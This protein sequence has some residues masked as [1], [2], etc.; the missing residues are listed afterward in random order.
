MNVLLF[1]GERL[2]KEDEL[3]NT[4]DR[5]Q[6]KA[7]GRV[8]EQERDLSKLWLKYQTKIAMFGME[9]QTA[10]DSAMPLRIISY[11]GASYRAQYHSG[12]PSKQSKQQ[13]ADSYYPV[14]TLVLHFGYE[15]RWN[16]AQK[17]SDLIDVPDMVR[18]YFQDYQINVFDIAYLTDEQL[19]MFQSDFKIVADYFVQMQRNGGNYVPSTYEIHHVDEVL[20]LMS[21]LTNDN[22]FEEMENDLIAEGGKITM[23]EVLDRVEQRGIERGIAQGIEQGK[24]SILI[25]L[26]SNGIITIEQAAQKAGVDVDT[27]RKNIES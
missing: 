10:A 12:K 1:H 15:H 25:E 8:H 6:Y 24:K 19:T 5:S 27:F 21:V 26:V 11:D 23:C 18:P 3:C 17:L 7:D 2:L 9:N 22:R 4:K 14:I 20:K 16:K 13:S